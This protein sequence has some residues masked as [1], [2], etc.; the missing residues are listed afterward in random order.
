MLTF[1]TAGIMLIGFAFLGYIVGR[2]Q[3]SARLD[4]VTDEARQERLNLLDE[5]QRLRDALADQYDEYMYGRL[6]DRRIGALLEDTQELK[7]LDEG[8]L[9][10]T[11]FGR[12]DIVVSTTS[13]TT[14]VE[15]GPAVLPVF[16]R[17]TI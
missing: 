6:S 13:T 16:T 5:N 12:T 2:W 15:S 10:Q 9:W 1:I 8:T 11:H 4:Q 17:A 7:T 14:G 3:V